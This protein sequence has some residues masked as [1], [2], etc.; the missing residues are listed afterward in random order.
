MKDSGHRYIL[1]IFPAEQRGQATKLY[2]PI[3]GWGDNGGVGVLGIQFYF[4]IMH[5]QMS[6][7]G[8]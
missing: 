8:K 2:V 1:V 4:L 7:I 3:F 5:L 6:Q